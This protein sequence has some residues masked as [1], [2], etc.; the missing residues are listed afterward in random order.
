MTRGKA[1][2]LGRDTIEYLDAVCLSRAAAVRRAPVRSILWCIT[3]GLCVTWNIFAYAKQC[4]N[5]SALREAG[6]VLD[7]RT[8]ACLVVASKP[9]ALMSQLCCPR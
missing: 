8:G 7:M 5:W 9:L 3:R 2:A 4:A 1:E 6:S